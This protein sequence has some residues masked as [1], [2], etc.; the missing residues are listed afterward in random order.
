MTT[1]K[2]NKKKENGLQK[3]AVDTIIDAFDDYLRRKE[4]TVVS[5]TEDSV[6]FSYINKDDTKILQEEIKNI[7]TLYGS[8]FQAPKAQL[9]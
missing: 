4:G 2:D 5:L 9:F 1:E 7:I 6:P 3:L 8:L